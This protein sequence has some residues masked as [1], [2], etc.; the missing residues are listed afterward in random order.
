MNSE[1][2]DVPAILRCEQHGFFLRGPINCSERQ[3]E[4]DPSTW[5]ITVEDEVYQRWGNDRG[6][7]KVPSG[8]QN[9]Y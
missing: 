7:N 2:S 1:N 3:E 8:C 9:S 4:R 5:I 6:K